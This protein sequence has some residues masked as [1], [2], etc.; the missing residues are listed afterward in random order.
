LV[1]LGHRRAPAAA[2]VVNLVRVVPDAVPVK[3]DATLTLGPEP[4]Q[5]R[6]KRLLRDR[7]R[8]GRGP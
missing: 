8:D 6:P 4:T 5:D 1:V 7:L 2:G 3:L